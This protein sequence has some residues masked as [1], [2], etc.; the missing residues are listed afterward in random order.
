MK[1]T[2]DLDLDL[3]LDLDAIS[4]EQHDTRIHA[5]TCLPGVL[6]GIDYNGSYSSHGSKD[7]DL[8]ED[9]PT[10][11]YPISVHIPE[12]ML[13][14]PRS[15]YTPFDPPCPVASE[16]DALRVLLPQR[17]A[18][19]GF[20]EL[21]LDDFAVYCD[22]KF[23]PEE[24][25][26]LSQLGTEPHSTPLFFDGMLSH[27]T[28][29]LY[30]RRVRIHALPIGNYGQ[31]SRHQT[32]DNI[33]IQSEENATSDVFYKLGSPAPEYKRFFELFVWVADLAKYFVDFLT[34]MRA[35]ERPV[36]I[37]HF[38]RDF[39]A[40]L[41]ALYA[42]SDKIEAIKT[43]M[44]KH[45]RQDY[46]SAV[47][48]NVDFLHKES[49]GVLGERRAYFHDLWN[50]VFFF[51]TYTPYIA[52]NEDKCTIVT[53]YIYDCFHH[54]PF[55]KRLKVVDLSAH[56]KRLR[57][58]VIAQRPMLPINGTQVT[59]AG[60]G[61]I[62]PGDTIST[63][64]D[65]V[66]SG[67][68]WEKEE[69]KGDEYSDLWFALVQSVSVNSDGVRVFEVIWYYRPVD[70]LCGL[71][72]YPW[73]NELFLSDHCSCEEGT[74]IRE[75]EVR[76]VHEV[77]FGG[78][79]ETTK[80]FF[81][82]QSYLSDDKIWVTL[83]QSHLTCRH[84]NDAPIPDGA[85]EYC[86]GDTVLVKSGRNS[87]VC[88]PCEIIETKQENGRLR[89]VFRKLPRRHAVDLTARNAP[90][91]EVVYTDEIVKSGP[92][93]IVSRCHVRW[94][95]QTG[96]VPTPY[97]RDGVGAFFFLT[98]QKKWTGN[99]YITSPLEEAPPSLNQGHD[100]QQDSKPKLR[101]LDLFCGG[102]NFGRGLEEGG[103]VTMKWANDV[104]SKAL[105]TY[106]ANTEPGQI[107]PFLGS[108][109]DFQRLAFQGRFAD[110]IPQVG[111]V[112]F[113]S[114]GSPCPGFSQLTNDKETDAQRK[115]QSLVA[116][117]AS[118]VDLYRP[119]YGILENV[120]GI[121]QK[122][123]N[124]GHDVF[125]QLMCALVGMGY[126]ARLVLL[127]ALSCGSAQVRSR[128]FIV[129]AAPGWTLPE[130]PIQT[131]SHQPNVKNF[132]LGRLPT[133]EPMARREVASCTPFSYKSASQAAAGLPSLY[134]ATPDICIAF[135]DH[136]VVSHTNTNTMRNRIRLIPKAPYGMN[137][138]Q[139]W[140][141]RL[142][143]R[144]RVAGRGV[145][146]RSERNMFSLR[147][148]ATM[149][150]S[151]QSRAYGRQPPNQ[152]MATIVTR[153]SPRDAKQGRTIHWSE[154][155]CLSVME[156]K[157]GQGFLDEELLL[158]SADVQYRIIGNSV[159]R[160]VS[161]ALGVVFAEAVMRS[162]GQGVEDLAVDSED[163]VTIKTEMSVPTT[164]GA[165][166]QQGE[167]NGRN[168][169]RRAG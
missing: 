128:V 131:H 20:L 10:G 135:P 122:H 19:N 126:Q 125:S 117:F 160:E 33:W 57:L 97:D 80:E 60:H 65:T 8:E 99:G 96:P 110:N 48:A 72:Q 143:T 84:S 12:C 22:T 167:N 93:S 58:E 82:R 56:T 136:R 124:R 109:D 25:R 115:N 123:Q 168:K 28:Q 130:A 154:D 116:A 39:A 145:L 75:D 139:A 53:K 78:T 50:E 153:A 63:A 137:F 18:K 24:M 120:A 105:H 121:I 15:C 27:G 151:I 7:D 71:M 64:R 4:S 147:G 95:P 111:E 87:N 81:C 119:K 67:T 157:R 155:R 133:G 14:S 161:L 17:Y 165:T 141:G 35:I 101:G 32:R 146:T 152:P 88:H 38:R 55:G 83:T 6:S 163:E 59:P 1:L 62:G 86:L 140:Y 132:K 149:S 106:M 21:K 85:E 9:S 52:R 69:A 51:Q 46:R 113:I 94:F 61:K 138:S 47:N 134:D 68:D 11:S 76:S 100:S 108:I 156:A 66:D 91:N 90:P 77:D 162:Y 104:N 44:C 169:R 45:P 142:G 54:L 29:S 166:R 129:F 40:W 127:D 23:R 73:S 5:T 107:Y 79:R 42:K 159:A 144:P 43:W 41:L 3:D 103:S 30:V 114:G 158:G 112:D 89:F 37:H 150:T 92:S 36:T 102:G 26:S 16:R 118:C 34:V 98:H 13:I 2:A 31:E 74:K 70:T 148:E 49:V 164:L